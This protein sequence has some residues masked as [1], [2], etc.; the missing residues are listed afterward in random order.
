MKWKEILAN[1]LSDKELVSGIFK[2]FLEHKR[3]VTQYRNGQRIWIDYFLRGSIQIANKHMKRCSASFFISLQP[4][5]LFS[6]WNSPG[7][8]TGVGSLSLL[9]GIIPTQGSNELRSPALQA[10]SLPAE[11]QGK[12][13]NTGVG[14]PSL[15]QWIFLTQELNWVSCIAG[16]FFTNWATREAHFTYK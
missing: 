11:P 13:K 9:Q 4:Y 2:E 15:L 8:N 5:G 1:H 6:Q 7:Q 3:Q 12:P 14:S 16:R 10:D